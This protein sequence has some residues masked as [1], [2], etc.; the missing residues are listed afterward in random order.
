[1]IFLNKRIEKKLHDNYLIQ[2][3]YRKILSSRLENKAYDNVVHDHCHYC[4][5]A[6]LLYMLIESFSILI[7]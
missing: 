1:M 3:V 2:V 7:Y 5:Y 6:M 4:L